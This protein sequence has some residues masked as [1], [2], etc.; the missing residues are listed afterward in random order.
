MDTDCPLTRGQVLAV[1][2]GGVLT[3]S[4]LAC[5]RAS[6]ARVLTQCVV[7][8]PALAAAAVG[9]DLDLDLDG[10]ATGD[11]AAVRGAS[12]G[13]IGPTTPPPW[14]SGPCPCAPGELVVDVETDQR[15]VAFT[16]DDGPWPRHT[17]GIMDAFRSR[18]LEGAATFF[19]I[20]NNV[21]QVG[22]VA[23]Q[24]V[25][26]G[27][28]V[29]NH[30][31]THCYT[32]SR[33]AAE[34]QPAQDIISSVC[35]YRPQ[36]F[37][38]PGL[39][40]GDVIQYRLAELGMANIFTDVD[41]GDWRD[42]RVSASVLVERFAR[43][44]HPGMIVLLHDGGTHAPTVAAVPGMLDICRCRGYEV[45]WLDTLLRMGRRQARDASSPCCVGRK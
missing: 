37:R 31:V 24:V 16:F 8:R 5:R 44:L 45:V 14:I 11:G 3:C 23:R 6:V 10:P 41:L 17:V 33:L 9:S 2:A 13:P 38:S 28:P 42:P 32:P 36:L 1:A 19:W 25:D 27:Y 21:L 43:T 29:A 7:G 39:T 34:I 12:V 40:R 26:R 15:V 20:A 4:C 30:S 18:G 35:G 22:D